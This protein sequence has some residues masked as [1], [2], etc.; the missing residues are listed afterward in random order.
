MSQNVLVELS[1]ALADA[2]EKAGKATV[3]V[4]ARRRMPASGIAY[5]SDLILTADHVVEQEE[6]IKVLLADGEEVSARVAGRDAGS[7]LAVLRLDRS[8]GAIAEATKSAARL[9]QIALALGRP[10]PDGIEAS[11]GTVSAIGG[12]IR[13]GRGGML[14]RYLR[15]DSISYPGFSGGPLVAADGTVLGLNTSGLANGA[16]V[17][18]PADIAWRIADTLVQH[19]RIKRGYLGIRS[20]TVDISEVSQRA[21]QRE[22]GKGLLIVGVE[23]GSPAA[24][25]GFMVGDILI[26]VSGE[27]VLHHDELFTRLNGDVVGKS[28]PI[29]LI[30]GGQPQTLN[31][32]IGEK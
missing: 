20:Q 19:G 29:D 5:A 12:P 14:E 13:T 25:G 8:A 15:T 28:L 24:K 17:T 7:D 22:Q 6:G 21:L 11:L 3:L 4:N 18:V 26:G 2:A 23:N 31:V 32:V 16:A 10:S 1:D 9:G 27:P 30:R